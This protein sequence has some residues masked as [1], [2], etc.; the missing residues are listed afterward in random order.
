MICLSS[1]QHNNKIS[2]FL[3]ND[4]QQHLVML[5][6]ALHFAAPPKGETAERGNNDD[7]L[8][9]AHVSASHSGFAVFA[10]SLAAAAVK[11]HFRFK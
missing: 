9:E 2:R 11:R 8:G 10:S 3:L 4:E 6:S 1:A 5:A 7:S